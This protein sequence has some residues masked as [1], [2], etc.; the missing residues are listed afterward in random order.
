MHHGGELL[1]SGIGGFIGDTSAPPGLF[2]GAAASSATQRK[3]Y[4]DTL[5]SRGSLVVGAA[6]AAADATGRFP[7]SGRAET[8]VPVL[9]A[10]VMMSDDPTRHRGGAGVGGAGS[11]QQ[12]GGGAGSARA[13]PASEIDASGGL[14]SFFTST[15]PRTGEPLLVRDAET[16]RVGHISKAGGVGGFLGQ[17]EQGEGPESGGAWARQ[18]QAEAP[19]SWRG[20]IDRQG[21]LGAFL[22]TSA[23]VPEGYVMSA[24]SG[25]AKRRSDLEKAMVGTLDKYG[26]IAGFY[27]AEPAAHGGFTGDF[28][29]QVQDGGLQRVGKIES[30]GL[31]AY[32]MSGPVVPAGYVAPL[33][34]QNDDAPRLIQFANVNRGE[35]EQSGGLNSY[36]EKGPSG[37]AAGK[38]FV[39][40]PGDGGRNAVGGGGADAKV[41]NPLHHFAGIAEGGFMGAT[42]A[43][44]RKDEHLHADA[45]LAHERSVGPKMRGGRIGMGGDREVPEQAIKRETSLIGLKKERAETLASHAEEY[46]REIM[47]K[48]DP[49]GAATTLADLSPARAKLQPVGRDKE[50]FEVGEAA[51]KRESSLLEVAR[52]R[53]ERGRALMDEAEREVM[54]RQDAPVPTLSAA[55]MPAQQ[56]QQQQQEHPAD[57]SFSAASLSLLPGFF[58]TAS[59]QLHREAQASGSVRQ[60]QA[61]GVTHT[62]AASPASVAGHSKALGLLSPRGVELVG[63]RDVAMDLRRLARVRKAIRDVLP[64]K[65]G[66]AVSLL[67]QRL[68]KEDGDSDGVISDIELMR[69][70]T[71]LNPGLTSSDVGF[72]VKYLHAQARHA[73]DGGPAVADTTGGLAPGINVA[74][75]ADF[76]TRQPGGYESRYS[77]EAAEEAASA[78]QGAASAQLVDDE[79]RV[80]WNSRAQNFLTFRAG[81]EQ[82]HGA[83]AAKELAADRAL[84]SDGPTWARAEPQAFK[85]LHLAASAPSPKSQ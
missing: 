34:G 5:F 46:E 51:I 55:P 25:E 29:R 31:G 30:S 1:S 70:L 66:A 72:I 35:L 37:G 64:K 79:G 10:D 13:G 39:L 9:P 61:S 65:G 32:M 49:S 59:A 47:R 69:G 84:G 75:V 11:A 16:R 67:R 71:V 12:A 80:T 8:E 42:M 4:D 83:P 38:S 56:Q 63:S 18:A 45:S 53:R 7:V 26:G 33:P 73:E 6:A 2:G 41:S 20:Q 40:Y 28:A 78:A 54:A 48:M 50:G 23:A 15:D 17:T 77:K 19:A 36:L 76:I 68:G 3:G 27:A 57:S 24:A 82:R 52:E 43:L 44:D 60:M 22:A 58:P 21:G 62:G 81:W 74:A 14:F 85:V